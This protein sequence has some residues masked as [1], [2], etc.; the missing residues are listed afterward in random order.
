MPIKR[1]KREGKLRVSFVVL[2]QNFRQKILDIK[3]RQ[4]QFSDG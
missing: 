4:R 1:L 3:E 2:F